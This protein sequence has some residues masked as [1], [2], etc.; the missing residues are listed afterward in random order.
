M[1]VHCVY[2]GTLPADDPFKELRAIEHSIDNY[3][4]P[5]PAH[6]TLPSDVQAY[7]STTSTKTVT[8]TLRSLD[9]ETYDLRELSE[10][11]AERE[12]KTV[13]CDVLRRYAS[14]HTS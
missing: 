4:E 3:G 6:R 10:A 9:N 12:T 7:E 14:S 5:L 11:L 8:D 2:D 1:T 13:Q